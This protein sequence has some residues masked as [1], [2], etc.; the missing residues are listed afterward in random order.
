M[1]EKGIITCPY[2]EK[3][4]GDEVCEHTV[5]LAINECGLVHLADTY[6]VR[7]P[8]HPAAYSALNRPPIP[9]QTGHPV[10]RV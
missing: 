3:E 10:V 9:V 8:T 1:C 6:R 4:A 5:F 7:I 2:C